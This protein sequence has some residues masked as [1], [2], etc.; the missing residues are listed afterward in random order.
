VTV[1]SDVEKAHEMHQVGIGKA[2]ASEPLMK[3]RYQLRWHQNRV[4]R[5]GL[6]QVWRKPIDWPGGARHGGGAR[7]ICRCCTERGKDT[8]RHCISMRGARG[9]AIGR[10]ISLTAEYRRAVCLRTG[11]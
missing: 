3:C 7:P 9:S 1:V 10:W 4:F 2:S 8:P 11:S 6:G 5:V